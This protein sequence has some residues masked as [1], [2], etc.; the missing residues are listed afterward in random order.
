MRQKRKVKGDG[1]GGTSVDHWQGD[2]KT[3]PDHA[4]PDV[5]TP[6]QKRP[7]LTPLEKKKKKHPILS[8]RSFE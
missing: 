1:Y 8:P 4:G 3:E 2:G 5:V 6:N 7:N